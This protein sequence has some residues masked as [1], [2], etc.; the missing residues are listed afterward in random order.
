MSTGVDIPCLRFIAFGALTK[1]VGN[2]LQMVGRGTRLDPKT[3]K[4]SFT[5]LDLV[6]LCARMTDHKHPVIR[7]TASTGYKEWVA[8]LGLRLL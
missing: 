6:G 1:S 2:C 3:G 8:R 7:A 4:F 5:I